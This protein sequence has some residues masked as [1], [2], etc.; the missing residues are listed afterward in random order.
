[1]LKVEAPQG[2]AAVLRSLRTVI[3]A[4]QQRRRTDGMVHG[5][6]ETHLRMAIAPAEAG[7]TCHRFLIRHRLVH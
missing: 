5:R 2:R 3:E 6:S 1:M 4:A 7:T